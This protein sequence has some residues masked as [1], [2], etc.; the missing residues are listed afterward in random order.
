MVHGFTMLLMMPCTSDFALN[1]YR[2]PTSETDSGMIILPLT[3]RLFEFQGSWSTPQPL[4][5]GL[6]MLNRNHIYIKYKKHIN[7]GSCQTIFKLM[8]PYISRPISRS[9]NASSKS[10]LHRFHPSSLQCP[11]L[12]LSPGSR[13]VHVKH[14]CHPIGFLA[15]LL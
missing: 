14:F 6:T 4:H 7:P 10:H 9:C 1:K 3:W 13:S 2:K 15:P 8:K 11:H 12:H 5:F